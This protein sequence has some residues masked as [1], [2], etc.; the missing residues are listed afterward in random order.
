MAWSPPADGV[1]AVVAPDDRPAREWYGWRLI[2]ANNREL[3]RSARSFVS[4]PQTRWAVR[5]LQKEHDR[6]VP[7]SLADP[8]TGRWS[9]RVELDNQPVAVSARWY[10]RDHDSR[11]GVAKF[12]AL[13]PVAELVDGLVTLY[14]RRDG[15]P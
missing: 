10:E 4:Y 5:S 12:V 7:R 3:G 1:D 6:L 8:A 9:W 11:A 2:G 13:L 15:A 14:G